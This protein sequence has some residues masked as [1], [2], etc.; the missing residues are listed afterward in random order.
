MSKFDV[1]YTVKATYAERLE[2]IKEVLGQDFPC[3]NQ[4]CRRT[5]TLICSRCRVVRYCSPKCQQVSWRRLPETSD[6]HAVE[7]GVN[8]WFPL[9]LGETETL[10]ATSGHFLQGAHTLVKSL[11]VDVRDMPRHPFTSAFQLT[12]SELAT[13]L[14]TVPPGSHRDIILALEARHVMPWSS[15]VTKWEAFVSLWCEA[16]YPSGVTRAPRRFWT[17]FAHPELFSHAALQA[18]ASSSPAFVALLQAGVSLRLWKSLKGQQFDPRLAQ[19]HDGQG[20]SYPMYSDHVVT[21]IEAVPDTATRVDL[22]NAWASCTWSY[23][24]NAMPPRRFMQ[25]RKDVLRV[26]LQ[27]ALKERARMDGL[28][29]FWITAA[30]VQ[31][32]FTKTPKQTPRTRL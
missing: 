5:G 10:T 21:A 27:R 8:S 20:V 7:C 28:R 6:G 13:L 24:M 9:L 3:G 26:E 32:F 2:L 31:H 4:F 22:K 16:A 12:W 14:E 29:L 18:L 30:V 25:K 1:T 11:A 19:A 15:R 17:R 23:S